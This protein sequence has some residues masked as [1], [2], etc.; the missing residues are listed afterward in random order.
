MIDHKELAELKDVLYSGILAD[1]LDG[2]GYRRQSIGS[3][4]IKPLE[5]DTVLF[6]RAF[7]SIGTTVYSMPE[8]PLIAQCKV[9]DQLQPG[10][11]YILKT[12][13]TT[14]VRYLESFLQR[15]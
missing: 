1:V 13:G 6:G 9:V 10:E 11:I 3:C 12:R 2:L 8:H 4:K 7:T 15:P 14:T 5:E